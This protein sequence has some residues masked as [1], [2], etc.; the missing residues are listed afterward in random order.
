MATAVAASKAVIRDQVGDHREGLDR[1]RQA[2]AI[3]TTWVA[4]AVELQRDWARL[5]TVQD[6]YQIVL[7][8]RLLKEQ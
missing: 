3:P 1:V 2:G 7:T 5:D 6:V 4:L 8:D